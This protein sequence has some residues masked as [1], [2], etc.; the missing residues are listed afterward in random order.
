LSL[1]QFILLKT[2]WIFCDLLSTVTQ[3]NLVADIMVEM[4]EADL[5]MINAGKR[6][7]SFILTKMSFN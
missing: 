6:N 4:Y 2:L 5:A 3:G 7:G 1:E